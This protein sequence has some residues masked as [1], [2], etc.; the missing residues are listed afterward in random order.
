MN[1]IIQEYFKKNERL[2]VSIQEFINTEKVTYWRLGK[3]FPA[4]LAW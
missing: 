1:Y 4:Y 2:K 3:F